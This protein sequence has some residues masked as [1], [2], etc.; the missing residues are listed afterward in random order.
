[1]SLPISESPSAG[2]RTELVLAAL[3]A[4]TAV[5]SNN[6]PRRQRKVRRAA[7]EATEDWLAFRELLET[8][9]ERSPIF[10]HEFR[11]PPGLGVQTGRQSAL[12]PVRREEQFNAGLLQTTLRLLVWLRGAMQFGLGIVSDRLRGRDSQHQRARRLRE[13]FESLGTTFIKVGQQLSMRLDLFPYAY[14]RELESMLDKVP[15]MP[16]ESAVA[17]IER[18]TGKPIAELFRQFDRAPIGSASVAC[19]YHAVLHTGEEVAVKVRRPNIGNI[20]AADMRAF[21][22]L[23]AVAEVFLFRPGFTKNFLHELSTMLFEE[24]DFVREARFSELYRRRMRKERQFHFVTAPKIF[25]DE[26]NHEVLVSEFVCGVWMNEIITALETKDL[27]AQERLHQMR[28]DPVLL[29][30]RVQLISRYNNFENI[31]FHA[32]LHPANILVQPG[33]RIVLIDF[34]SCGSFNRRELNSW[35]AWF[36]A[37]SVNDIGGMVQAA[38]AIIEPLP[39]IDKDEFGARLEQMFWNDLY[40]IKSKNSA[41]YERVSSRLWL[42]FMRLTREFQIPMRLNTLRMIRASMLADTIAAR[43]DHDQNPYKEFRYYERGAGRRAK[44]RLHK[45]LRQFCSPRIFTRLEQGFDSGVK[46]L[47]RVQKT[48]ESL[49]SI[50][51]V[52]LVSKAAETAKLII[53]W[54]ASAVTIATTAALVMVVAQFMSYYG[55]FGDSPRTFLQDF[56]S[57]L[58]N[59]L[60]QLVVLAIGAVLMRRFYYRM[61]DRDRYVNDRRN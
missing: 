57:V 61:N 14:T 35:R 17:T 1:M 29:A 51:I 4:P 47:Y 18:T 48:V 6:E 10:E 42:G 46:L 43:L 11:R 26:S 59:G 5:P 41:W 12:P 53:Q 8:P 58:G 21:G 22:W 38:M 16:F 28:L 34:G 3:T 37:Q 24:L 45:R 55:G 30:R 49:S 33:N 39:P 19:V 15:P 50:N 2:E 44:R 52:P 23:L 54:V 60:F 20:L 56:F 32:D 7:A 27:A 13:T 31:F 9:V 40:A 25:P 36:D